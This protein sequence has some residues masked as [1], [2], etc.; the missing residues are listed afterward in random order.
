LA[1][2][3]GGVRRVFQCV[4][5]QRILDFAFGIHVCV[6]VQMLAEQAL[7]AVTVAAT[8]YLWMMINF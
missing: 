2:H 5:N 6:F 7:E 8:E 3:R 4:F 1:E